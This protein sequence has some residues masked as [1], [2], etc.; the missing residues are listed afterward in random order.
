MVTRMKH[1]HASAVKL[2]LRLPRLSDIPAI[3]MLLLASRAQTLEMLPFGMAFFAAVSDKSIAYITIPVACAGIISAAGGAAIPKYIIA[4]LTFMIITRLYRKENRLMR[5]VICGTASA[6]GGAIMLL[7]EFNGL[8]DIFLLITESLISALVYLV[9]DRSKNISEDFSARERMS[10]EEYISTAVSAGIIISGFAGLDAGP[11]SISNVLSVY[12][13]L[14]TALNSSVAIAGSTGLCIGFITYMSAS[15]SIAMMGVFGMSAVFACFLN[16]Y[17]KIGCAIGFICGAAVSLIYAKNIYDIPINM[18]DIL[19]GAALFVITPRIIHEYFRSFFNKSLQ[20]ESVSPELRMRDYLTMRLKRAGDA[21]GSLYECFVAVSDGRLKKY[22]DDIGSI[23]DD[24][25]DRVCR[26][27]S[28]C[29]KCWQTDFR[30]TYK[31]ILELIGIIESDGMLTTENIPA[32]FCE[33][34][35]RDDE[36]INEINHVYEL[37]KHEVLRRS[38]AVVTR[39]LIA[40][41]YNELHKLLADMAA[42]IEE[43]FLFLEDEE[44]NIVN[45]LDKCGITPYEVSAVESASGSCEIYLRLPPAVKHT[46]V[47]GAVSAAL[48]RT[49]CYEKTVD[50]LSKY[51][52]R[53][54][55][56][57]DSAVL[58]LP[59]AGSKANGDSVTVFSDGRG[60]FYAIAADGMGSGVEA[61]YESAAALRLLTSFL[62]SG[63]G[64]KTALGI[65]NSSMCLNMDNESYSTIDLLC[66]DLY[67][68]KAELYK[69]GSAQTLV[70]NGAETKI[71]SSVSAPAG[72]IESIHPD[73]KTLEL[74]EGD[75][76]LMMTDGITEA[77]YAMSKTDW[78]KN[79]IIKPHDNMSQLAKEVMDTALKKSRSIAKDDMSV[80]ALRLMSL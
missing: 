4:M 57:F 1:I 41:Q 66:V 36:F 44:E 80:I 25:T 29:G 52:S 45:E 77:G 38:D 13:I 46:V 3:A 69:I 33:R 47:E 28:M 26:G 19:T 60:K 5:A 7:A 22:S 64:V 49:V 6:F 15:S 14:L 10:A 68:G 2:A 43:G 40:S 9:F 50:G 34:C 63:F 71:L 75:V 53:P 70:Y 35:I 62:K 48:G 78:I 20:I 79:I 39:N 12:T 67:T 51:V 32:H 23:L 61:Q 27:C 16:S 11:V 18:Y 55:Y 65:L 37:Y 24:T 59:Q 42:D 74:K 73:K 72:I 56:V 17:K 31:N 58:Q 21:F 30:R 76:I 54:G 8:Y